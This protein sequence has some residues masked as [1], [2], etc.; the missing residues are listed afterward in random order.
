MGLQ[1]ECPKYLV[2]SVGGILIRM[3][4]RIAFN[5]ARFQFELICIIGFFLK[6]LNT[7]IAFALEL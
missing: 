5:M 6:I 2:I 7:G 1:G 3:F 4:Q